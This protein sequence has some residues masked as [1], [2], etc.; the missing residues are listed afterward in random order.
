MTV[1]V[2]KCN[3][4]SDTDLRYMSFLVEIYGSRESAVRAVDELNEASTED[5]RYEYYYESWR[6]EE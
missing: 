1:Y 3:D 6:V 4:Y 2:V 5:G